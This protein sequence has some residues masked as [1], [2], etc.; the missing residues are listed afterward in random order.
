[1]DIILDMV[2]SK[3]AYVIDRFAMAVSVWLLAA[4]CLSY[5][6][7]GAISAII[8]VVPSAIVAIAINSVDRKKY[9]NKV[10]ER[11]I[12]L[13]MAEL[14]V[15]SDSQTLQN[16]AN[17]IGCEI[18]NEICLGSHTAIAVHFNGS[19]TLERLT[20][21]YSSAKQKGKRL[22]VLCK[23]CNQETRKNL[24]LFENCSVLTKRRSYQLLSKLNLL[25][26]VT[27]RKKRK[28]TLDKSKGKAFLL[29]G[30]T[31]AVT[32]A[33]SPYSLFCIA[34]A[35]ANITLALLCKLKG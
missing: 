13:V 30:A 33:F 32:A 7:G 19:L 3:I 28:I 26:P 20:A 14:T 17:K 29:T 11:D 6:L 16:V 34:L 35:A 2:K 24:Y 31:L 5:A 15:I 1:M 25:P 4:V 27:P 12:D 22:L 10:S 9:R 8:A 18:Y 21:A 23:E